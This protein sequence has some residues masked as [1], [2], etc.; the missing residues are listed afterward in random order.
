MSKVMALLIFVFS[1][2]AMADW[3]IDFSRRDKQIRKKEYTT[4]TGAKEKESM[5]DFLFS[6][7]EPIQDVV[8]L[9]T[10]RGFVPS[11]LRTKEGH[12][13]RIHV[14]NV[15]EKEKNV[16]FVLDAFSEHHATYYGKIKSFIITPQ[17]EGV[18]TFQSP[19][20]SSQGRLVVYPAKNSAETLQVRSPASE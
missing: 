18:Y 20:T 11:T 12:R 15:N 7:G 1:F 19:E 8:L 5:F 16:S 4:P 14:V 17:K 13:Y 10:D 3:S 6:T 9:N 2:Q